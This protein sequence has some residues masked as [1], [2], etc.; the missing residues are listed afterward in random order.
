M[1]LLAGHAE[2]EAKKMYI[3]I[4]SDN[5]NDNI[6]LANN[7]PCA[8]YSHS[9]PV[10]VYQDEFQD[11]VECILRKHLREGN[12]IKVFGAYNTNVNLKATFSDAILLKYIYSLK[13][14]TTRLI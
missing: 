13:S 11:A 3:A 1:D 10:L 4:C 9:I 12:N 6:A 5:M 8:I 2:T 14:A 7:M